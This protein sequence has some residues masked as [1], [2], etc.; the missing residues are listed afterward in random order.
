MNQNNISRII[1]SFTG[2]NQV[3]EFGSLTKSN[4]ESFNSLNLPVLEL[5]QYEIKNHPEESYLS[6]PVE[7][8]SLSDSENEDNCSV[9]SFSASL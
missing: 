6:Q 9:Y 1:K 5:Y 8:L 3:Y 2:V 4:T 7:Y